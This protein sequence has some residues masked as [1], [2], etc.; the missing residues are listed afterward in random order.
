MARRLAVV[1][2]CVSW[3]PLAAADPPPP[4]TP[5]LV[6]KGKASFNLNCAAC[7][8]VSGEGNGPVAFAVKPRPRNLRKDR[9]VQGD[10]VEQIFGTITRGLPSGT[11]AS[12]AQLPADERWALAYYVRSF[13]PALAR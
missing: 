1:L 10:A 11:M 9:F 12:Y 13:R 2:A 4:R 6:D 5:G 8:G 7:H 3:T